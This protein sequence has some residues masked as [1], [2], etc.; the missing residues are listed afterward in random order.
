MILDDDKAM[1]IA[2]AIDHLE[3]GKTLSEIDAGH[4]HAVT[5]LLQWAIAAKE[6][7]EN[8]RLR[9]EA[10]CTCVLCGERQ[11]PADLVRCALCDQTVCGGCCDDK[12]VC[13]E[14]NA[15]ESAEETNDG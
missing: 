6:E 8:V 3:R 9:A 1:L 14:C 13:D 15:A 4:R 11:D 2:E 7:A 10:E 5:G 12:L